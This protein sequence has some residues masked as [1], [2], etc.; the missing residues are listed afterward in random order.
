MPPSVE[1]GL[2]DLL[3]AENLRPPDKAMKKAEKKQAKALK[4]QTKASRQLHKIATPHSD[5]ETMPVPGY[6]VDAFLQNNLKAPYMSPAN[7]SQKEAKVF[8]QYLVMED[9]KVADVRVLKGAGSGYDSEA[10]RVVS[11]LPAYKT[12]GK[13]GGKAVPVRVVKPV[14]FKI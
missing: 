12:P 9:G 2:I 3:P 7:A 5:A 1:T 11:Q 10:V 4:T 6:D 13:N 14:R 8:V